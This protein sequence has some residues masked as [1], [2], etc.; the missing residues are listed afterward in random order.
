MSDPITDFMQDVQ[1]AF[2]QTLSDSA[3]FFYPYAELSPLGG[4]PFQGSVWTADVRGSAYAHAI[5]TMPELAQADVRF[6]TVKPGD[7]PPGEGAQ[8]PFDGGLLTLHFWAQL[9]PMSGESIG[10]CSWTQ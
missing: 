9:D 10:A 4:M 2:Q 3:G 6:V 7:T 5:T 8:I 1:D